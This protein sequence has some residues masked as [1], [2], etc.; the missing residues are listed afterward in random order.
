MKA[1]A[2]TQLP[3]GEEWIY[4]VKWDGYRVLALKHGDTVRLLSL[5]ER[6]LTT[7][8][9]G[10]AE[11][12]R[13]IRADIA[14]IDGEVVALDSKGCPSFQ[15]LQNRATSGR[16]WQILYYAFDLLNL[17][18]EDWTKKPL[19][20]RK[21]KLCS[22]LSG[23]DIRFNA[24]LDGDPQTIIKAIQEA[25]LE[26]VIAKKR[27]SHYRA[28]TRVDSWLKF[29]IDKGQE[30]V[31]GGYKPDAGSFQSI[32]AGYYQGN[33]LLFAGKVRQG[34]NPA[35]RHRLLGTM[36]SLT[37]NKCPFANLPSSRRSHFGE[38]ITAEEMKE[39][40]WL[41]PKLV[42]QIS[43][44]EWTNYGLLRHATFQGLRDDKEPHDV[45][46]ETESH[47]SN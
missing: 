45:I 28:G 12:V 27:N 32:L 4:E 20:E 24:D 2:V 3:K 11:A 25:G 22:L 6:D 18:G 7:D 36:R 34:F 1:T 44:T 46:R 26:G 15:A 14:L 37:T 33:K 42:A 9:P 30:F 8:F 41:K 38:G 35:S 39:L 47:R 21:A 31:I 23:S 13:T 19:S 17:D 29:K 10:V 5:K 40:C 43:F 16:A